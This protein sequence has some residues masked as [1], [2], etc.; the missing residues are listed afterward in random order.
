VDEDLSPEA[1]KAAQAVTMSLIR[2][3]GRRA[4][5]VFLGRHD[6]N[7][8]V[9]HFDSLMANMLLESLPGFVRSCGGRITLGIR[10]GET[11]EHVNPIQQTIEIDGTAHHILLV[12]YLF[13]QFGDERVVVSADEASP[14]PN[15]SLYVG[16]RSNRDTADFFRRWQAYAKE[17]SYLRGRAFFADGEIIERK[18]AYTYDDI[19]LSEEAKRTIRTHVEGFLR[20]RDRLKALGAKAR[21]G[22]ILAGPPGT[23]KTLLGKVLA[24][25]VD[26]SFI[27]VSP[28]H[29]T[30]AASFE[31]ILSVAR[32]VAP[33]VLFFEDLDL[34][35]GERESRSWMGLGELM[36]VLDGAVDNEDIVTIATTNRLE[37]VEKAL[38]NR[39]GR[40]DRIV[41]FETMDDDCRRQMFVRLLSNADVSS[42]DVERLVASTEN[43][44]GAQCEEL[45]STLYMLAV[46]RDNASSEKAAESGEGAF[47]LTV[48]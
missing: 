9:H 45:V 36:N 13:I 43:Y 14:P 12:G 29:I 11:D 40:F 22:L 17:H 42:D 2:P 48:V 8:I 35:A 30:D 31:A 6:Y 47:L 44:T 26:A 21:R 25:T 5:A 10:P 18:K 34:F 37:T 24:E 46:E 23:G 15:Y 39:P 16:V 27:W 7:K 28:R 41:K 1:Q 20:N 38:R 4:V 32:F 3:I 19:I 33:T